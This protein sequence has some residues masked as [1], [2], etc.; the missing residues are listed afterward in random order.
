[1]LSAQRAAAFEGRDRAR[2][3]E[4]AEEAEIRFKAI[5]RT[6]LYETEVTG[7]VE[8]RR[9]RSVIAVKTKELL[10]VEYFWYRP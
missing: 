5:G 10:V 2:M 3:A 8:D 4:T 6:V 9:L 1:M 7:F